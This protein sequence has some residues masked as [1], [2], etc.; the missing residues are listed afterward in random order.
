MQV[1]VG[2]GSDQHSFVSRAHESSARGTLQRH[3]PNIDQ[4]PNL[5][6]S[7]LV[8]FNVPERRTSASQLASTGWPDPRVLLRVV[9]NLLLA[10]PP[11]SCCSQDPRDPLDRARCMP[12]RSTSREASRNFA[13]RGKGRDCQGIL[14][15]AQRGLVR[16][17]GHLHTGVTIVGTDWPQSLT[18]QRSRATRAT[19]TPAEV[20]KIRTASPAVQFKPT[21]MLL[22][23][24]KMSLTK[25]P[26][27]PMMANPTDV[28]IAI[29][30][31]SGSA[32]RPATRERELQGSPPSRRIPVR[33]GF[34][35]LLMSLRLSRMNSLAGCG[36]EQ[37]GAQHPPCSSHAGEA[38]KT[39]P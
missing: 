13:G 5:I 17:S 29:F 20:G 22:M 36:T 12:G 35:H 38:P 18:K 23:G 37:Q 3:Q 26:M 2:H 16:C 1:C 32:E 30:P 7:G 6:S 11:Q 24:M 10:C 8:E 39:A 19:L 14:T 28:A 33:S 31:N 21:M 34:V 25:K 15:S 9:G 4:F 27:K